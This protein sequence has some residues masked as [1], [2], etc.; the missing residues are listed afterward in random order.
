[1]SPLVLTG[2]SHLP[3]TGHS[4]LLGV[5]ALGE[6]AY[7][8]GPESKGKSDIGMKEALGSR[9]DPLK[10]KIGRMVGGLWVSLPRDT[11]GERGGKRRLLG[12]QKQV[13]G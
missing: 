12:R 7:L 1:M 13:P 8:S 5:R 11:E 4:E 2:P 10:K 9:K 6:G 3:V